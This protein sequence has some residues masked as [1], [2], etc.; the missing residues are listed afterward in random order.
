MSL[1]VY[2]LAVPLIAGPAS[3][4]VVMTLSAKAVDPE[5]RIILLASIGGVVSLCLL[6]MLR[7]LKLSTKAKSLSLIMPRIM[8]LML[9]VIAVQFMIDGIRGVLPELVRAG[10]EGLKPLI[11]LPK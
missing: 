2:P 3:I 9:A 5:S 8:G 7:Y 10:A 11:P 1:G 6:S 4:T